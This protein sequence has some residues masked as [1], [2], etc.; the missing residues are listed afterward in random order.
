MSG[1]TRRIAFA[2][3]IL[4]FAWPLHV[5]GQDGCPPNSAPHR[6][7][8]TQDTVKVY[9]RC[10]TGF[11]IVGGKCE[12]VTKKVFRLTAKSWIDGSRITELTWRGKKFRFEANSEPV[13]PSPNA[14]N[15]FKIYQTFVAEVKLAKRQILSARFVPESRDQRAGPT[16]IGGKLKLV[17]KVY[18]VDERA[19][20]SS[21]K[22]RASFIRTVEG[23]P[24][25]WIVYFD[26]FDPVGST[27]FTPI[28]NTLRLDVTPDG[29]E[30]SGSGTAFPS[31]RFWIG[32]TRFE[33]QTQ[34][35]PSA[36]FK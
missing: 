17:G 1:K 30:W 2:A 20:V 26:Y 22:D 36:Y 16:R 7:Q 33:S 29:A 25:Y 28:S 14:G 12:P 34:V 8:V 5:W 4:L 6:K 31:H 23:H 11:V 19:T 27:N 13:T 24:S 21:S 10:V 15:D 9:C 3:S 18:V 35:Q 32:Q